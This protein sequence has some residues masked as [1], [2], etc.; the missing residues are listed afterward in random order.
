MAF[1]AGFLAGVLPLVARFPELVAREVGFF[2]GGM[3]E[4]SGNLFSLPINVEI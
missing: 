2:F 1:P 4:L 3:P